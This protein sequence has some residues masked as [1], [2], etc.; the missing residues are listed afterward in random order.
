MP[1][2]K[3]QDYT[4]IRATILKNAA[5]LFTTN[6]YHGTSITKI[7]E[8]SNI[9]K[10]GIYHYFTSKD[11]ILNELLSQHIDKIFD[12]VVLALKSSQSPIKQLQT[13]TAILIEMHENTKNNPAVLIGEARHLNENDQDRIAGLERQ[14]IKIVDGVMA[15]IMINTKD[16]QDKPQYAT[17]LYFNMINFIH[18]H[19]YNRES[20]DV[21]YSKISE[22][23]YNI[24]LH[25]ILHDD[26]L[27]K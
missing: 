4:S 23:A 24:F 1:R 12:A 11:E 16:L 22:L 25:G 20:I 7:S 5:D 27:C 26:A 17:I 8:A 9:S 3:S 15:N 19:K 14:I 2:T 21:N 6:G 18:I 13:L 10:S